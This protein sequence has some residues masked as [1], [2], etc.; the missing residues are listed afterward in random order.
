[1]NQKTRQLFEQALRET[2]IDLKAAPADVAVFV[3]EQ[4]AQLQLAVDEPGFAIVAEAAADRVWL[5]AARRTVKLADAGDARA[6]ELLRGLLLGL[7]G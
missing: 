6:F 5:Y 7:V 2:G 3:A 1:M 4:A